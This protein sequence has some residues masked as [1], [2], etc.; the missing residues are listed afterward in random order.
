MI[1]Y[2]FISHDRINSIVKSGTLPYSMK[3]RFNAW[4][5]YYLQMDHYSYLF[6]KG[7]G[8]SGL[9]VDGMFAK[10]FIDMGILGIIIYSLFYIKLLYPYK[11]IGLIISIYC[12]SID[13]FTASKL[14][15]GMYL[16]I[17]YLKQQNLQFKSNNILYNNNFDINQRHN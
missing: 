16:S 9:H 8:F 3:I 2:I 5:E 7:L 14:M 1:T 13:F 6:G 12:I 10:I 17:Y 4:S 11:V 15:F